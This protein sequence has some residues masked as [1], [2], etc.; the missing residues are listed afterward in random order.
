[1]KK[2]GVIKVT[3]ECLQ[4]AL[5]IPK[6]VKII[7]TQWDFDDGFLYVKVDGEGCPHFVPEGTR[8]PFIDVD[9]IK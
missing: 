7:E 8:I 4:E 1:M 3:P 9:E 5:N 2:Q 6:T